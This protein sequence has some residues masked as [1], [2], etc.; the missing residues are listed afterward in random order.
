[1]PFLTG[2]ASEVHGAVRQTRRRFRGA[3]GAPRPRPA[4]WA[5][6]ACPAGDAAGACVDTTTADSTTVA[7]VA[8]ANR[9]TWRLCTVNLTSW[10]SLL[11]RCREKRSIG[12]G[13]VAWLDPANRRF[14]PISDCS[15]VA[16][17]AA[18]LGRAAL[19]GDDIAD[20]HRIARPPLAH[21]AV[22]AAH[23]EAPVR[24]LRLIRGCALP[25]G[26]LAL[27]RRACLGRPR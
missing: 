7:A 16:D 6:V 14:P 9:Q 26:L 20:F 12:Y 1:M 23:L 24:H 4:P 18:V 21:E 15:R 2:H 8:T 5:A 13:V 25:L 22:R 19:D 3:A 27:R 11:T 10:T 17:E